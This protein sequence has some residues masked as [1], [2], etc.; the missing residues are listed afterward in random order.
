MIKLLALDIDD[1]ITQFAREIPSENLA[2]IRRAQAAGIYVTVA[3]GRGYLGSSHIWRQIGIEGPV[4]NYG[5]ALI[6]DTRTDFPIY[7]TAIEPDV[8][9]ELFALAK[10]RDLHAQLYQGDTIVFAQENAFSRKYVDMLNLPY[11]VDADVGIKQWANVPKVLYIVEPEKE[12]ALIAEFTELFNG[13]LKVSASKPGYIE[14]NNVL[15]HKGSALEWLAKHMG[16]KQSEVAAMGDNLLD[17]EMVQYAGIGAAV[18]DAHSAVLAVA[19]VIA[20]P[21]SE[22]GAAWFIDNVLLNNGANNAAKGE[23]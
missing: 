5:G 9:Q 11:I 18:G 12:D 7:E 20:P 8:V 13:R 21:C 19:D 23:G 6:F 3:T 17:L 10:A 16:F 2:A 15:A 4:I 22:L 14:F 1:T